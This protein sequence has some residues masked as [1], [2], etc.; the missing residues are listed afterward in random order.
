MNNDPDHDPIL[1]PR[2]DYLRY[3]AMDA[4]YPDL[5]K[6]ARTAE[7]LIWPADD[8][9]LSTDRRDWKHKLS[10]AERRCLELILAF[11]AISDGIVAENLVLNFYAKVHINEARRFYGTQLHVENVHAEVYARFITHLIPGREAQAKVFQLA[12]S[13]PAAKAKADWA[14]KWLSNTEVLTL[15]ADDDANMVFA[16]QLV[17][18][19]AVE[20]V[21]FSSSFAMP[22]WFRTRGLMLGFASANDQIRRDEGLHGDFAACLFSHL[23]T[24]PLPIVVWKIITQAVQIEQTFVRSAMPEDLGHGMTQARMCQYVRFVGDFCLRKMG[25]A[26]DADAGTPHYGDTNPLDCVQLMDMPGMTAFFERTPTDYS[27]LG[28]GSGS[29]PLRRS[30]N[31]TPSPPSATTGGGTSNLR[32]GGLRSSS[33][34]ISLSRSPTVIPSSSS[35]GVSDN[36]ADGL[37]LDF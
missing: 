29:S 18:F 9:D 1:T 28:G 22:C 36:Q 19:A 31:R 5:D 30:L 32:R 11:F 8:I 13:N 6:L 17:A 35:G 34:G 37:D 15:M 14:L 3:V 21:F 20:M 33:A 26:D 12:Q 23:K 10:K 16:Q 4:E 27:H 25:V 24:K 7:S 2:T